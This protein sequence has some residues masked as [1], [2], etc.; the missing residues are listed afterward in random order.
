M[1]FP[2]PVGWLWGF[3]S[4]DRQPAGGNWV[5]DGNLALHTQETL[6]LV[7][8]RDSFFLQHPWL[9]FVIECCCPCI[10]IRNLP[11]YF[12]LLTEVVMNWC[13]FFPECLVEFTLVNTFC[14]DTVWK[15]GW[16][17]LFVVKPSQVR[18][19]W[20]EGN[21]SHWSI[22]KLAGQFWNWLLIRKGPGYGG[23]CHL[24]RWF[25]FV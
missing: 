2:H 9:I 22:D 23:W 25:W 6:R 11:L 14:S 7:V 4:S 16:L 19:I 8:I 24:G 18:V 5:W 1:T 10:S 12:C 21:H 15:I 17:T 20:K 13:A 3:S